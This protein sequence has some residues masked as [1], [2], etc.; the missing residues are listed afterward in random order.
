MLLLLLFFL[1]TEISEDFVVYFS[2]KDYIE[3]VFKER[4]K[5]DVLLKD[6][7]YDGLHD[8]V[9]KE[10]S[11]LIEIKFKTRSNGVLM[12]ILGNNGYTMLMVGKKYIHFRAFFHCQ[13]IAGYG[14]P[15][16]KL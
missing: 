14:C 10:Y 12:S 5:R 7:K 11:T 9:T 6:L 15:T 2:G 4:Y 13:P 16:F 8:G 1:Q 3:Y